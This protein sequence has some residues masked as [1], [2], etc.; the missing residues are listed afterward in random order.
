MFLYFYCLARRF[1][2]MSEWNYGS[3][4]N[5]ISAA[6]CTHRPPA[7]H[8]TRSASAR[9]SL[10]HSDATPAINIAKP[11]LFILYMQ[12]LVLYRLQFRLR[13]KQIHFCRMDLFL[14]MTGVNKYRLNNWK[15]TDG[16]C[17]SKKL[18]WEK[19]PLSQTDQTLLL[20][21]F[22]VKLAIMTQLRPF[23]G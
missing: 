2:L 1:S 13:S 6:L 18:V 10:C 23:K 8:V 15:Q 21:S 4:H 22:S 3:E 5:S 11:L 14:W 12:E 19:L 7:C 16:S 9:I 17:E 20:I